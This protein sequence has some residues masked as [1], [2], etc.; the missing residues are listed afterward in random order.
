LKIQIDVKKL[1]RFKKATLPISTRVSTLSYY[2]YKVA[3]IAH[4]LAAILNGSI[5]ANF[6]FSA[7]KYPKILNFRVR[8][9]PNC[10]LFVKSKQSIKGKSE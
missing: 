9:R 8:S 4:S 3:I 5:S 10:S 7:Q 6:L 2:S 1:D